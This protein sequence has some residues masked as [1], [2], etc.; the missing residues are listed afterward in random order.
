MIDTR[1]PDYSNTPASSLRPDF[2]YRPARS[3]A[4][5]GPTIAAGDRSHSSSTPRVAIVTGT[6]RAAPDFLET[7]RSILNQSFQD[8]EWVIIDDAS[9]D[10]ESR[11][12]LENV[13]SLDRRI[14]LIA[15]EENRGPGAARN[16][17][18]A[19][20][21]ADYIYFIDD[22]DLIEPTTLEKCLWFLETHPGHDFVN[23]WSVAFGAQQYLWKMGFDRGRE[24][25]NENYATGRCMIRRGALEAVG[26]FDESLRRGFEDW[27]LWLRL[28]R[29]GSWGGTIPEFMDWYRR[30]QDH[31]DRWEDWDDRDGGDRKARFRER[32]WSRYG[33]LYQSDFPVI[34][35]PAAHHFKVVSDELP[36]RNELAKAKRRIL[37]IVPW[38]AIG[39]SD[40]FNL[41]LVD[42][43]SERDW[44]ITIV[45]TLDGP[46]PWET[47]FARYTPDIFL[48]HRFLPASDHPRFIRY[49][50]SSRR[51]DVVFTSHSTLAY[52]LA[53]YLRARCPDPLYIDYCHIEEE[54]W[55]GG[56]YPRMAI[57]SQMH[58]D[59]NLVTSDHLRSWMID[60]GAGR[61]ATEVLYVNVDTGKWKCSD[62]D[63]RALRESWDVGD[64]T[65]VI[66]FV[67]R[68]CP[69]KQPRVL[70]KTL[71]A[72][73]KR[74][75]RFRAVIAGDG[76]DYEKLEALVRK[77]GIAD[78]VSLMGSVSSREVH[79][80]M[81]AADVLFLPSQ[82]EGIAMVIYEAM[83]AEL[84]VVGADVGGQRELVTPDC[85]VLLPKADEASEV[86]AYAKALSHL[87]SE[88][89]RRHE[90]ARRSRARVEARFR[91]DQMVDGFVRSVDRADELR[92]KSPEQNMSAEAAASWVSL[93]AEYQRLTHVADNLWAERQLLA[94]TA[95][96]SEDPVQS[97]LVAELKAD[98]W[99]NHVE[100]SRSWRLVRWLH[101]GV[102]G[103][104]G[105]KLRIARDLEAISEIQ[106]PALRMSEI[107]ATRSYRIIQAVKSTSLHRS[108]ARMRY[109]P[110][111]T[112]KAPESLQSGEPASRQ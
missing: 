78:R 106:N 35:P 56:G 22:D 109:G 40:K 82:W 47:K 27:D 84:V 65:P 37:F 101:R 79:G 4:P 76:E 104:L 6:S 73:A 66:L 1:D 10:R 51:P 19:E 90:M 46:S 41:D 81:S 92:Q 12:I 29:T 97:W 15:H 32:L 110:G 11:E 13:S 49:L 88:P 55:L 9:P 42:G 72:L 83:A 25:L 89:E 103:W 111:R 60:R 33:S 70:G 39:G 26:G 85:G 5:S 61:D 30:R 68:I 16:T 2:G 38:L 80:L 74:G 62:Q 50:I 44:E 31:S 8:W 53:P 20:A 95:P 100:I 28:A 87:I 86:A 48:L 59:L 57:G 91:L 102:L 75:L 21:H 67:G 7:V 52:L 99:L 24:F 98:A 107:A 63:R 71:A 18:V 108:W 34:E 69:Q 3:G 64:E 96:K 17:G 45:T 36:W 58:F 112:P 77:E 94:G 14:R 54:D 93:V 23:G 105:R 43:L